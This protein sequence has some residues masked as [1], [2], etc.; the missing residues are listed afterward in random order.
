MSHD[1]RPERVYGSNW[2]CSCC[3][4]YGR[5]AMSNVRHWQQKTKKN[6]HGGASTSP[7]QQPPAEETTCCQ[8][9]L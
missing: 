8:I 5:N 2:R 9:V 7:T 4:G 6:A 1:G 3:S